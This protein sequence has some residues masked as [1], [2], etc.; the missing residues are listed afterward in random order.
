[1]LKS[2]FSSLLVGPSPGESSSALRTD[3]GRGVVLRCSCIH[4]AAERE[5]E[6]ER[7]GNVSVGR[8]REK[9]CEKVL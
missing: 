8:G 9:E 5:R 4:C 1:M 2:Y 7:E 6:R 3:H